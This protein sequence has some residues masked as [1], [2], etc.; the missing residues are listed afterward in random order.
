MRLP[1]AV[2]LLAVLTGAADAAC[3][4]QCVDGKVE[5]SCTKKRG[6]PSNCESIKCP[7][8]SSAAE[9]SGPVAIPVAPAEITTTIPPSTTGPDSVSAPPFPP[10]PVAPRQRTDAPA[11]PAPTAPTRQPRVQSI[12]PQTINRPDIPTAITPNSKQL[13]YERQVFN[14]NTFEYEWQQACD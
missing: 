11:E 14:P 7:A 4:C 3:N 9:P 6:P 5:K 13:C 12:T 8:Q 1:I 2:V 10:S